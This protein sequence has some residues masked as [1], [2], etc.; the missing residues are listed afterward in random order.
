MASAVRAEGRWFDSVQ[1]EDAAPASA[2]T[3]STVL[4]QRRLSA[5][6]MVVHEVSVSS[7]KR[8]SRRSP[9]LQEAGCRRSRQKLAVG[10][11]QCAFRSCDVSGE[12]SGVKPLRPIR[13]RAVPVATFSPSGRWCSNKRR[14]PR[15]ERTA[16]NV[17]ESSTVAANPPWTPPSGLRCR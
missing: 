3:P 10:G 17:T 13:H 14:S 4:A 8:T 7:R 6:I 1:G 2:S 12:V 15:G 9:P 11:L 5:R 16:Q